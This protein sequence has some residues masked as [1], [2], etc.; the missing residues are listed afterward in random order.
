MTSPI[1]QLDASASVTS[2]VRVTESAD[3]TAWNT[4]VA[5]HPQGGL[6]HRA[7]WDKVFAV[8]RLPVVR[9]TAERDGR[10]VGVL[11][12]VRQRS[13]L[14]GDHLVSLPWFD[15]S[16]ILADDAETQEALLRR[17]VERAQQ[18]GAQTVQFRQRE[19]ADL[20]PYV[21]TD[22]LLMRLELP[23]DPQELWNSFSPKVRNQIRK[24]EKSGLVIEQG[25]RELLADFYRV[26]ATNMRDLGSPPH[27]RQ[28]FRTIFE[29][30]SDES[31]LYVVRL[32]DQTVGAGL[33]MKNGRTLE[34]PWASSL[35]TFNRCCVNH[36]MYWR[37]LEDACREGFSQ[38]HFGRSSR[39]SGT[40]RF[41]KQWGA[42]SSQLYWY[43]IPV[44]ESATVKDEPAQESFGWQRRLW[45]H[46][47]VWASCLL[48]P[49][50]IAKVS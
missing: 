5:E 49:R 36:A 11:W 39:D 32:K 16:G 34:I 7:E 25:G 4:Y 24:G 37:I 10:I 9:L 35:R 46:L 20:S 33:T 23:R 1:Q 2:A 48:G 15:A 28:V 40:Y 43:H 18:A 26:Y 38:F 27:S 13:F 6:F 14:F 29:T 47:P 44:D 42:E 17:A 19:S 21:R 41:K 30:F 22:K 8:Y 12:L 50:I 31:R 3:A 45:T